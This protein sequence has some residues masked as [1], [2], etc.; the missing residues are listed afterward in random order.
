MDAELLDPTIEQYKQEVSELERIDALLSTRR[1]RSGLTYFTPNHPQL[2][3]LQATARIVIYSGGNRAGKSSA[4]AFWLGCHLTNT[5]PAC[6][7]H[8]EWFKGR[9]FTGPIKAVIA[10]TEYP[11][12]ERVIEPKLMSLLPKDWIVQVKRTPQGYLRR[13]IGQDGGSIDI[14]S[15]EMDQLAFEGADWDVAWI[16]EPTQRGKYTAIQRG[17]LDREGLSFLTFT[18]IV[19]PWMKEELVDQADGMFIAVID[20][21]TYQNTET[22]HG[23][24]ILSKD[25]IRQFE[26]SIPEE[27]R[28]TRIHGQF[29][30]LRGV[31]YKEFLPGIHSRDFTYT[32]P[33]P[34]ICVLDPHTRKPHWVVWAWLNRMDQLFI[35][36]ELVF[37]GTLRDLA[38]T[39]ILT[40]QRAGYHVRQRIIDP[41]FGR[42]PMIVTGRTVIDELMQKPFPLRFLESNDDVEA[43]ILKIKQLLHFDREQPISLTNMPGI[44]FH[45]DR[46]RRT[47]HSVRNLQHEEWKGK[48]RGEKDPKETTRAKDDDGADCVRYLGMSLPRYDRLLGRQASVELEEPAYA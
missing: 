33:D 45:Q 23:E 8:G 1:Q 5:Y 47:I 6:D 22:I 21:D 48:T 30:H 12:I 29:F 7:C 17:L 36:R 16:D 13:V 32:Y 14:L 39:I 11:I 42:T 46:A 9:R 10:A 43:G 37:E 27:E 28:A 26:Q 25:A 19:E 18:P 38:K 24:A 15:N 3:A 31:V 41:N 2:Q 35:D 34:V 40:E 4:G 44:Y 20:A